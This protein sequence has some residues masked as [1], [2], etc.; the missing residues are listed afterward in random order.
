MRSYSSRPVFYIVILC[1]L[2]PLAGISQSPEK[3]A[4]RNRITKLINASQATIGVGIMALDEDDS[5]LINNTHHYPMQ[6][7]YKF[8]L[9]MAVLDLVDHGKLSLQKKVRILK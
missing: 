7:V 3:T 1:V 5:L 9:A 4:L 8:P 6:S 2:L